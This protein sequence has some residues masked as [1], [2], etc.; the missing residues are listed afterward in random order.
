MHPPAHLRLAI[1]KV[2]DNPA[3]A[4]DSPVADA[5]ILLVFIG[6]LHDSY[7]FG[8]SSGGGESLWGLSGPHVIC[9][10]AICNQH[11]RFVTGNIGISVHQV[12]GR[13]PRIL[14]STDG[15]GEHHLKA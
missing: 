9:S 12:R 7:G 1:F 14:S 2:L 13:F 3:A 6:Y 8:L 11:M 5:E 4:W 10:Q 15:E